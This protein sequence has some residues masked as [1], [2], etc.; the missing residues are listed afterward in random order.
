MKYQQQ[1]I[2][3]TYFG[4][5]YGEFLYSGTLALEVALKSVGVQKGNYVLLPDNVCY[6]VLLSIVRVGAKPVIVTPKNGYLMDKSEI[7]NATKKYPIKAIILV[8]QYGLPLDVKSIKKICSKDIFLIEDAA[9]S[10]QLK[11]RGEKVGKYS[12]YV[13]TSFGATKPLSLGIG[14]AIF[15]N[16]KNFRKLLNNCNRDSRENDQ[17][18]LPYVLPKSI[19]IDLEKLI[20][21]GNK[22]VA[23]Q[24]LIANCLSKGLIT[25]DYKYWQP[26]VGDLP[27]WHRFPIWTNNRVLYEKALKMADFYQISYEL[28]HKLSLD[29]LLL[30]KANESIHMENTGKKYYYMIIKTR[31][32]SLIKIQKWLKSIK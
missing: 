26:Q 17:V 12:D 19:N 5:K 3:A 27:S 21:I 16:T 9:Q 7:E 15:G 6:Q 10:W 23:H 1:N 29:K 11:S 32:N 30:A 24:R 22:N 28:P 20:K 8:H 4:K 14:G 31:Q 25:S 13:I 18:L 2:L